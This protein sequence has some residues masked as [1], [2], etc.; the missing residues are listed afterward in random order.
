[1]RKAKGSAAGI[2]KIDVRDFGP[3]RR[4]SVALMP[5]TILLGPNNSGK[6]CAALLARCVLGGRRGSAP[7][8][9]RKARRLAAKPNADGG[10]PV[11]DDV[12]EASVGEFCTSFQERIMDGIKSSFPVSRSLPVGSVCWSAMPSKE[13]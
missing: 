12:V 11:R 2:V 3:I 1:M 8:G 9:R 7:S 6:S 5:M 4:G 13:A 10:A